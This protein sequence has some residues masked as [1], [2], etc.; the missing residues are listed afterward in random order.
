MLVTCY[1]YISLHVWKRGK[2]SFVYNEKV[3]G[4]C[5]KSEENLS[6][7]HSV[8]CDEMGA[9]I[10]VCWDS[11][12]KVAKPAERDEVKTRS[13]WEYIYNQIMV[14]LFVKNWDVLTHLYYCGC[15][16]KEIFQT[17]NHW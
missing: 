16:E 12:K 1:S 10:D 2:S 5:F 8:I 15:W 13:N 17:K 7:E 14:L 11:W 9:E 3:E 4:I 6:V